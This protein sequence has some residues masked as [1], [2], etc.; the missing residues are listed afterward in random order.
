MTLTLTNAIYE[1]V[2]VGLTQVRRGY[3]NAFVKGVIRNYICF[4]NFSFYFHADVKNKVTKQ[5]GRP[6]YSFYKEKNQYSNKNMNLGKLLKEEQNKEQIEYIELR[7]PV[8]KKKKPNIN[9]KEP[10]PLV[11]SE[12]AIS[13]FL[14]QKEAYLKKND[15]D[16]F[17]QSESD[18]GE[19]RAAEGIQNNS[20]TVQT[21]DPFFDMFSNMLNN[22]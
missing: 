2:W 17:F 7:K 6:V 1:N 21:N 15:E 5:D 9:K 12:D 14:S 4:A 20:D 13:S 10:Q 18:I 22:F 11:D 3:R 16:S 19:M 8:T